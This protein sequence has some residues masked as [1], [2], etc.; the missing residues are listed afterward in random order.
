MLNERGTERPDRGGGGRVRASQGSWQ[1]PRSEVQGGASGQPA[2]PDQ[3]G[4]RS[5]GVS[6]VFLS[7]VFLF[8]MESFARLL[9]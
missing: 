9:S 4:K 2:P 8:D 1:P 3:Q 6:K 7:V 5:A